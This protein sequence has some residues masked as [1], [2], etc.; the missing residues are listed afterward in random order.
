MI[1]I[2]GFSIYETT[3]PFVIR[4]LGSGRSFEIVRS[5]TPSDSSDQVI[6]EGTK[7]NGM[8]VMWVQDFKDYKIGGHFVGGENNERLVV[9]EALVVRTTD[10]I[11]FAEDAIRVACQNEFKNKC[12]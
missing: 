5:S 7:I 9:M 6:P 10:S 3:Q 8:N 2:S 12:P 11:C 1:P 4:K